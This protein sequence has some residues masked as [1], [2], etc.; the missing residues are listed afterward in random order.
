M[1]KNQC[2]FH[3]MQ[4]YQRI[5]W[6][7]KLLVESKAGGTLQVISWEKALTSGMADNTQRE[8]SGHQPMWNEVKKIEGEDY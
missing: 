8:N 5:Q 7:N 2:A 4:L 3:L 1:N 6:R